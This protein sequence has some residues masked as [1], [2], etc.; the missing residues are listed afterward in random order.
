M[1]QKSV[2]VFCLLVLVGCNAICDKVSD[3]PKPTYT[4]TVQNMS[5]KKVS[6][7]ADFYMERN[8]LKDC[9]AVLKEWEIN[10]PTARCE[11]K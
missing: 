3:G 1:V 6:K 2:V 10:Y 5:D 4:L 11:Q 7:V 9:L 8:G